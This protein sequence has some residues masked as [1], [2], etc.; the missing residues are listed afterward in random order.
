MNW[1]VRAV[2]VVVAAICT[3]S[4]QTIGSRTGGK[5]VIWSPPRVGWPEQDFSPSVPREMIGKLRIASFPVILEK[6]ELEAA[7]KHFGGTIGYRGDGGD[8]ESWLCLQGSD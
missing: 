5:T 8:S 1:I 2:V 7:H 4:A 3:C 6:T